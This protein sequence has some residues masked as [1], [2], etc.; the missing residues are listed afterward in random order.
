MR[1]EKLIRDLLYRHEMVGVPGLGSFLSRRV[2]ARFHEH[3]HTYYPPRKELSFNAQV[4][5][6]DG[7][8]ASYVSRVHECSFADATAHIQSYVARVY[9]EM[10]TKG[11]ASIESVGRLSRNSEGSLQ[12]L[13]VYSLNLLPDS[14]GLSSV[15]AIPAIMDAI[16]A[17]VLPLHQEHADVSTL[18]TNHVESPVVS[19]SRKRDEVSTDK[20]VQDQSVDSTEPSEATEP[21]RTPWLRYAA[22]GLIAIGLAGGIG[23][24][25][26]RNSVLE[27]NALVRQ[28]VQEAINAEIQTA[29]FS[30]P[31]IQEV[32]EVPVVYQPG[33][34]H[35]IAGAFRIAE[36]AQTRVQQLQAK[37]YKA[38]ILPVNSYGLTPVVYSSYTDR[39]T[40][41][42]AMYSIRKEDSKDAWLLV[43]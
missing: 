11:Y 43:E 32:V 3:S 16:P 14:F 15:T 5:E 36:N 42:R 34:F 38:R 26:Y 9:K 7:L 10:D 40:A 17:A 37:G 22:V 33:R 29:S 6:N 13:P 4:Q 31:E 1:M 27:Q 24:N 35:V 41:Q 28:E 19:L 20:Q 18:K 8:L 12:F 39:D 2:S 25:V 23:T 21:T 30:L